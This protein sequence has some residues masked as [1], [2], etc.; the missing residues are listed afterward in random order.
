V[1]RE[2]LRIFRHSSLTVASQVNAAGMFLGWCRSS[3]PSKR[4][5]LEAVYGLG[6]GVT[7]FD[8]NGLAASEIRELWEWMNKKMEKLS[9]AA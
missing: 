7:E 6:L 5:V 9:H 3:A 1:A 2:Q 4:H 8:P